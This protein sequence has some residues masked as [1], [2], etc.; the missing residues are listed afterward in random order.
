MLHPEGGKEVTEFGKK[1]ITDNT[2]GSAT[3]MFLLADDAAIL[4]VMAG[5]LLVAG[6][7]L[8]YEA[9]FTDDDELEVNYA[10]ELDVVKKQENF[11]PIYRLGSG[12]ST[13]LTPRTKDS[14]TGLS[15]TLIKPVGVKYTVIYMEVVNSTGMLKAIQDGENHVSVTPVLF[16][17]E[18]MND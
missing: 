13:N 12:T 10:I 15:Y 1:R 7:V 18:T 14:A 9:F 8:V 2:V 5:T 11:T 3:T 4:F 17:A 16:P 6:G